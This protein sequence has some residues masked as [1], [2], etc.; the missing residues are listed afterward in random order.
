MENS[1]FVR[2]F[3]LLENVRFALALN[4][5]GVAKSLRQ[6][7]LNTSL[8]SDQLLHENLVLTAAYDETL[9]I[10]SQAMS[11]RK[12]SK[13]TEG[14]IQ[15]VTEMTLALAHRMGLSDRELVHVRRG[16]VLHDV[17][18]MRSPEAILLKTGPLLPDER[19]LVRK[20]PAYAYQML[21]PVKYLE[22]ALD[23]PYCHHE[24]YDGTGYPRGL[25]GAEIP[26]VARIFAVVDVFDALRSD[27]P[28]RKAWSEDDVRSYLLNQAGTEFDP[29]VVDAFL[30]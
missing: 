24:R 27:R 13:E 25:K 8:T 1:S 19:A 26:L 16:A 6:S 28:Y 15:R 3:R 18:E 17:G 7:A 21:S 22:P 23:I 5:R 12:Q 9:D 4:Q 20:H 29:D 10:W 14:H 2:S 11:F 30:K